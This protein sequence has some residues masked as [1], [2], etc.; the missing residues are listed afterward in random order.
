M[1]PGDVGANVAL[2][3]RA[4]AQSAAQDADLVVFPEPFLSGYAAAP[5]RAAAIGAAD[6]RL[7]ALAS[8]GRRLA[9]VLGLREAFGQQL[10]YNSAFYLQDQAVRHTQ[11]KVSLVSYHVFT[12]DQMFTPGTAT[13]AFDTAWA[14]M[15]IL[16]CNDAWHP[17]LAAVL[18][19][20][21]A[22]VIVI[23][24]ASA[25]ITLPAR[26]LIEAGDIRRFLTNAHFASWNETAPIDASSGDQVRHWLSRA[27]NRQI[28][29][30]CASRPSSSD[31]IPQRDARIATA[32]VY[33]LCPCLSVVSAVCVAGG[34][35]I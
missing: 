19:H 7:A 17:A 23:P 26:L 11:H 13:C 15:G 1:V 9:A 24:A 31:A 4:I 3:R 33:G 28:N 21:G 10:P 22:Q 29:R 20:D 30:L 34:T 8:P 2:A 27:G 6:T 18:A 16:I 12:E 35:D 25:G 5:G 32:C 14:R